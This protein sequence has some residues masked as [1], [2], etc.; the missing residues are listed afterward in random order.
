MEYFLKLLLGLAAIGG[1]YPIGKA[2]YRYGRD[3]LTPTK[4]MSHE[5]MG[6]VCVAC[7]L[8]LYILVVRLLFDWIF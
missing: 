5:A 8:T 2:A 3:K 7:F 4:G 6:W 1:L